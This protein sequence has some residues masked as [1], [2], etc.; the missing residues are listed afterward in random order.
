MSGGPEVVVVDRDRVAALERDV[1][2]QAEV[3]AA[4]YLK[5]RTRGAELLAS[6]GFLQVAMSTASA[7]A[8]RNE[9]NLELERL[10]RLCDRLEAARDGGA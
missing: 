3:V 5:D 7:V 6:H 8:S 4:V 10:N 2:R 1:L 9:L